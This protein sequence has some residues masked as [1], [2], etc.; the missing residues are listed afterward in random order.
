MFLPCR[1]CCGETL[2][3][4]DKPLYEPVLTGDSSFGTWG[5]AGTVPAGS[6]GGKIY[7]FYGSAATSRPGGGAS[8]AEQE[9]WNNLCNWYSERR[10]GSPYQWTSSFTKRPSTTPPTDATVF[11]YTPI[12]LNQPRTVVAAYF[13]GT[14]GVEPVLK[15]GDTLTC[16]GSAYDS[17]GGAVFHGGGTVA[18]TLNTGAKFSYVVKFSGAMTGN[19]EFIS[20]TGMLAG[21]YVDGNVTIPAAG[22]HNVTW[23]CLTGSPGSYVKTGTI[24]GNVSNLG[25]GL[26]AYG[27][28]VGGSWTSSASCDVGYCDISDVSTL[29]YGTFDECIHT[30]ALTM[31]NNASSRHAVAGTSV[32]CNGFSVFSGT[33]SGAILMWDS[34]QTETPL[35]G[36]N[37]TYN[38][39]SKMSAASP[40]TTVNLS[41]T[42][43]FYDSSNTT[44]GYGAYPD[45]VSGSVVFNDSSRH[46]V[47]DIQTTAVFN[48]ASKCSSDISGA[49]TFNDSAWWYH[50]SIG[51]AT[52]NDSANID[53]TGG[54]TQS[55]WAWCG[56]ATL[57]NGL[58]TTRTQP[59]SHL[60]CDPN[61]QLPDYKFLVVNIFTGAQTCNGGALPWDCPPNTPTCGCDNN[62]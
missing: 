24:T 60:G 44:S 15:A 18:G 47:G 33:S 52:F 35:S 43:T 12:S 7:Y 61:N 17:P 21:A 59:S 19:A 58:C 55:Q 32:T 57:N 51:T 20:S 16:T 36:T 6:P 4:D 14:V 48:G 1:P 26:I 62:P 22:S 30:G 39:T 9:D 41:G 37:V 54:R 25:A 40:V 13:I 31:Y 10:A 50:G 46:D 38:N 56:T 28:V 23:Y 8:T 45:V 11:I 29:Y 34:S 42:A 53:G 5:P 2:V 3:C 49:A 27:V